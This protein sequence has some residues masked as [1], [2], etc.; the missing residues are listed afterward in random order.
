MKL[1]Y[2]HSDRSACGCNLYTS[3]LIS[4]CVFTL[5]STAAFNLSLQRLVYLNK[6]C[7]GLQDTLTQQQKQINESESNKRR[8]C[9]GP[10]SMHVCTCV[11]TVLSVKN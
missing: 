8:R 11:C 9:V 4:L 1:H 2:S 5:H 10:Q 6:V 7:E 3:Y